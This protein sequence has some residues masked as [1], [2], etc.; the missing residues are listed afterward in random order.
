MHVPTT[1]DWIFMTL[2]LSL[3]AWWYS[4]QIRHF[5]KRMSS[6]RWPTT[7]ATMQ[8]GTVGRVSGNR[9]SWAYGSFFGYSFF[10]QNSPYAGL[11][12][13]IGDEEHA[14]ALQDRLAGSTVGIRYNPRD[15]S[16]SFI[17]DPYDP[18]FEGLTATQNPMWLKQA[19][20]LQLNAIKR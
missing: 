3:L 20:P 12:V 16:V 14:S 9:A 8:K 17:A 11:F 7:D 1:F 6:R 10:V 5:L 2:M 19:P 4:T 18:R 15:P 13:L